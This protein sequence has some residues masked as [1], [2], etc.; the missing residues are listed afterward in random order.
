M[1]FIWTFLDIKGQK[2]KIQLLGNTAKLQIGS[3]VN[4]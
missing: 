2:S 4:Q 3:E 1:P